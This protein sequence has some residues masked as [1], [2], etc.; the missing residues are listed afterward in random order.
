M[1]TLFQ[2]YSN[3]A[4]HALGWALLHSLWQALLILLLLKLL[5]RAIPMQKASLRYVVTLSGLGAILPAGIATIWLL[6]PATTAPVNPALVTLFKPDATPASAVPQSLLHEAVAY[7]QVNMPMVLTAW[8]AGVLLFTLR[9][10]AG[11]TYLSRLRKTAIPVLDDRYALVKRLGDQLGISLVL[12]L[13]ESTRISAP[14]VVGYFKPLIL[15]PIGMFTGLTPKQV[16]AVLLHEL[17]HVRRHDFLVNLLQSLMEILYFFNP[18]VWMMSAMIREEREYCCDDEVVRKYHPRIY[19]EAL[20][21]LETSRLLRP[22]LALS[23][24]GEKNN[25]LNRIQRFMEKS[26]EHNPVPQWLVATALVAVGLA[27][28]SWLSIGNDP[29]R[30]EAMIQAEKQ[31]EIAAKDTTVRP[32]EKRATYSRKK[33]TTIDEDGNP[34]EETVESFDGDEELRE[35]MTHDFD[36]DLSVPGPELLTDSVFDGML[37]VELAFPPV[38]SFDFHLD[39]LDA[40]DSL[41]PGNHDWDMFREEFEGMFKEKFSDFYME[42]EKD[43]EEMM[44]QLDEKFQ[45]LNDNDAWKQDLN[46]NVEHMRKNMEVLRKRMGQIQRSEIDHQLNISRQKLMAGQQAKLAETQKELE[47]IREKQLAKLEKIK[48]KM[49]ESAANREAYLEA[50]QDELVRDGY[51]DKNE[52]IK[53]LHWTDDDLEVNGKKVKAKDAKKYRKM[54]EGNQ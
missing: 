10:A 11:W 42:H 35:L 28:T 51:L 15:V 33:I 53:S 18:F 24:T 19:A 54:R 25:L 20:A 44:D 34:H 23:L 30:D 26:K 49:Q 13:A 7:L 8:I 27:C 45:R 38:P 48:A 2:V 37:D 52:R 50:M 40:F 36:F 41:P 43:L 29:A 12:Q 17:V 6:L 4:L 3:P 39:H 21:Y 32:R 5:L 22:G 1:N 47:V 16:E 9:L 46:R 31:N 14:A